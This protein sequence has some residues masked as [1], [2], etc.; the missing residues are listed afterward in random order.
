MRLLRWIVHTRRHPCA[1]LLL[2]QLGGMLL[3]PF[4]EENHF[5]TIVNDCE[6]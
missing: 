3:Y 6:E 4:I 1:V 5:L 2:V